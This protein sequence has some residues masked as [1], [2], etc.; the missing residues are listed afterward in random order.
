M[1]EFAREG[2]TRRVQHGRR[3][4]A[5]APSNANLKLVSS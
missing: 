1:T 2:L 5:V 4:V 3:K